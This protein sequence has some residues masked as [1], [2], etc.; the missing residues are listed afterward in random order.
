MV[1]LAACV[2]DPTVSNAIDA[3]GPEASG[4]RRGPLHRP[5]QPCLLCHDGA[6]GDP[7][8][9]TVAGTVFQT[10]GARQAAASVTVNLVDVNGASVALS[11]N[12]AGNFYAT[13]SQYAPTFPMRVSVASNGLTVQM[14]T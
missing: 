1:L 4:V 8:R 9:F 5:G 7:P 13:P 6:L 14:E 2:P 12:A 11:T 3:L 10:T